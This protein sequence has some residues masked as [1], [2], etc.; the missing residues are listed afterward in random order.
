VKSRTRYLCRKD[1]EL[2]EGRGRVVVGD[3]VRFNASRMELEHCDKLEP[4]PN[5]EERYPEEG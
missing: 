5:A 4:C 1:C 3:D 2:C